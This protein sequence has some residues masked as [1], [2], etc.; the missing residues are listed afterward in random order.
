MSTKK[1]RLLASIAVGAAIVCVAASERAR[2]RAAALLHEAWDRSL[3]AARTLVRGADPLAAPEEA[4]VAVPDARSQAEPVTVAERGQRS[5]FEPEPVAAPTPEPVALAVAEPVAPAVAE[6]VAHSP[7]S[8]PIVSPTRVDDGRRRRFAVASALGAIV[9]AFVAAGAASW[10]QWGSGSD[11]SS[12]SRLAQSSTATVASLVSQPGAVRL[13]LAR[14]TGHL[15]VVVGRSDRAALV[16]SNLAHAPAGQQYEV[17]I[18]RAGE[19]RRAGLFS[20]GPGRVAVALT[21][22]LP[23]GATVA[24]TLEPRGGVAAP[25]GQPLFRATRSLPPRVLAILAERGTLRLPLS[26]S[27]GRLQIVVGHRDRAILISSNMPVAPAGKQYEVW[28]IDGQRVSPAGL[29]VGGAGRDVVALS[30]HVTAGASVAVTLERR[31]GVA[32]PTSKPHF[33]VSRSPS[34]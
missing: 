32:A 4:P 33:S 25:S 23:P 34:G 8:S 7:G 24:V 16:G 18:V 17:W 2:A 3:D 31:G 11:H 20:G 27:Q 1:T 13:P 5:S 29:F 6:P 15:T 14:S 22:A 26:G 12:S 21:R 10:Q 19:P 30:S 28:V 9:C